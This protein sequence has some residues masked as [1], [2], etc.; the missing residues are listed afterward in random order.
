MLAHHAVNASNSLPGLE[1]FDFVVVV[2]YILATLGIVYRASRHQHNTDDFFLG[3]RRLPWMAVGLSIMATL[4]SSLTYLSLTGEV[5]K[6]GIAAFMTQLAILPAAPFVLFLFIPFFMRLRYTSA[7]EYLE[8]RF[9][10]RARLLGGGLFFLLRLLWVSMVMYSGSLALATMGGWNFYATIAVL[11]VVA[12]F[13][14]YFGGLEGVVWTDVVQSLM[15]F[16]GAGAIVLYVW[17]DTGSGPATWWQAAAEQSAAHRHIEWFSFDPTKRI[18]L[19]TALVSGFVW[20]VCTHCSDQV[21]L[22]RYAST[23]SLAAARGSYLTNLVAL[24]SITSLLAV[25][26]LALLYYYLQHPD[27]LP[28]GATPTS[29]GDKLMPHFYATQLP[30]GFGGLILANFLCDAMQTLVSGVNSITAV[31]TQDVLEHARFV[32]QGI[33]SRLGLARKLTLLLGGL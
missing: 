3:N 4:L 6:S 15:L 8:H 14:T 13:Y 26:G 23:P 29:I 7:Y 25:S 33:P 5:V 32:K 28:E 11:G 1:A 17:L 10:L 9:D 22:Q 16:G 19:G 30:L 2:L 31:A 21:V 24:L 20:Q 27:R 18:T 12:T